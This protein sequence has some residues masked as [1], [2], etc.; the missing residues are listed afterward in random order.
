MQCIMEVIGLPSSA[1]LERSTRGK[2]F[3]ENDRT[4][5]IVPNSRG[6][7]RYPGRKNL[8]EILK[9]ADYGLIDL[10]VSCLEWDPVKRITPEEALAHDWMIDNLQKLNKSNS[11]GGSAQPHQGTTPR[12]YKK[13][14]DT[15]V[16]PTLHRPNKKSLNVFN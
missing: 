13:L 3:F 4:P 10:V 11:R 8:R 7:I 6:K 14:S 12:H 9:G 1:L 2:L 15:M 5:K 16:K